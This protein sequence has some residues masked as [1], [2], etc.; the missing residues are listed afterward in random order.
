[1][2]LINVYLCLYL[3]F[4]TRSLSAICA[5]ALDAQKS[6]DADVTDGGKKRNKDTIKLEELY[7]PAQRSICHSGGCS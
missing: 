4:P 2:E 6:L 5:L 7:S 3:P 1:M